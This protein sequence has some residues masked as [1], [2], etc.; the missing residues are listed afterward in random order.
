MM[1]Q[2]KWYALAKAGIAVVSLS[3]QLVLVRF[4]AIEDYAAYTLFVAAAGVLVFLTMFGMDRVIYRF[5]PPL[6]EQFHW[7]EALQLMGGMLLARLA[8][9]AILLFLLYLGAQFL[10]PRQIVAQLW[11]IRLHLAAY[12]ALLAVSDSLV[13]FCNSFGLQRAQAGLFFLAGAIRMAAVALIVMAT[14]LNAQEVARVFYLTEGLLVTALLAVLAREISSIR[15]RDRPGAA[16]GTIPV[17]EVVRDAL[18]TQAAYLVGFPFKGALLKLV[19]GAVS[20]PVVT[21]AFGFFQT[22]A[23]RAYQ[24]MPVFMLKGMLEPA[25]ASDYATRRDPERV[26]MT[27]SLLLRFNFLIIFLGIAMLAGCG[28]PLVDWVTRGRYGQHMALAILIAVQL[29]G[30]T[31]GECM[32]FAL[33]PLGRVAHH[34][35]MWMWFSLPFL[36]ALGLAALH[37]NAHILVLVATLPYLC[38]YAWLRWVAREA[39]LDAGLGMGAGGMVRLLFA[40]AAGAGAARIVLLL[41]LGWP[42]IVGALFATLLVYLLT[43]RLLGFFH[44]DEISKVDKLSPRLAQL[45]RPFATT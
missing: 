30:M 6:R 11:D 35:R 25:L 44:R 2:A 17:R 4:L 28:E 29:L 26:R 5:M 3:T 20:P 45:L 41:P 31:V 36:L 19:V 13:I 33:N 40:C 24:F 14:T 34:N 10:L 23:D 16:A 21:A 38:V 7:R 37:G 15:Q 42:A 18:S 32:F 43:L 8:L 1:L 9:M 27:V 22:M 39:G 12:A